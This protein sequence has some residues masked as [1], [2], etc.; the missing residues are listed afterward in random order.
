MQELSQMC[1]QYRIV[2]HIFSYFLLMI[3]LITYQ[4]VKLASMQMTKLLYVLGKIAEEV[5]ISLQH[6]LNVAST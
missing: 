6:D 1:Y 5:Q 3:Y 2:Y 4:N